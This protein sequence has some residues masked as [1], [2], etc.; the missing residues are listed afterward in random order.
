MP[1]LASRV[2][3]SNADTVNIIQSI[4]AK[5]LASF[6]HQGVWHIVGLLHSL[7]ADKD[8]RR[9]G[10]DLIKQAF[11]E[12]MQRKRE[13]DASM[14]QEAPHF[15]A[16]IVD[17]AYLVP[18]DK[19]RR[20]KWT[21]TRGMNL[22]KFIIPT[23]Q[24]LRVPMR[25]SDDR[26]MEKHQH[27]DISYVPS[28]LAR[29]QAFHEEVDIAIS[30]AKPKTLSLTTTAGKVVKFLLKLEKNGDL[31]K[32]NRLM[33]FNTV[34]NRLLNEDPEGRR[35]LLRLRT[36][37]VICLNE[38]CG[39]LEWVENTSCVRHLIHE[40]HSYWP[41]GVYPSI[42]FKQIYK[43]FTEMQITYQNDIEAMLREYHT[44]ITDVYHPCFHR[45]FIENFPDPTDWLDARVCF[46]R[47]VAV[48]SAVGHVVGL[49][50][51]HSENILL[52]V[53][54]GEC[55]QVDFDCLFD[56][57]LTLARPEIVPFRLTP[58]FVDAMGLTGV[59]G[60]FR[61]TME[62]C[63]RLL[64]DNK[65]TLLSVLEPFI[66]DPTV[67][68][69]RSGRA[70]R[71]ESVEHK[72]KHAP[73]VFQDNENADAKEALNKISERLSGIYNI[74]HPHAAR[75]KDAYLKRKASV[76]VGIGASKDETLPLSVHGQ[77]Q[78]LIFE[79]TAEENLVQM[80]IG[81]QPWS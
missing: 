8:R 44:L 43:P 56:K 35:R 20:L 38:E 16:A 25:F 14:I 70:Q 39:L 13:K 77:V 17:L 80:Y 10:V 69:G 63:M 62:V 76:T 26:G 54:K 15:F 65:E 57:G 53:T 34:V 58:N 51:R 1:H 9:I 50:D 30:K 3:H 81:W 61:S 28:E 52:D 12:L 64:R 71:T 74:T 68:W 19:E 36:F 47:S 37:S 42:D 11:K 4:L 27:N 6:P 48:W 24:M 78:R 67:Q 75:I 73:G 66:R 41:A 31:R 29:I 22:K 18:K 59:E 45:W 49:G 55:V 60:T 33:E 32:D 72:E 79:A 21:A 7:N 5:V 23:Q 40:S 46:T 2:G